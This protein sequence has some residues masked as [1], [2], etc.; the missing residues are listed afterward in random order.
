[1]SQ[2][3]RAGGLH[4]CRRARPLSGCALTGCIFA[5]FFWAAQL[6]AAHHVS[7][8]VVS[9]DAPAAGPLAGIWRQGMC[10]GPAAHACR[11]PRLNGHASRVTPCPAKRFDLQ[12]TS[13][14]AHRARVHTTWPRPDALVALNHHACRTLTPR[15][16]P[17]RAPARRGRP[18]LSAHAA[19]YPSH[20]EWAQRVRDESLPATPRRAVSGPPRKRGRPPKA[21]ALAR[22]EA[23]ARAPSEPVWSVTPPTFRAS[24][25]PAPVSVDADAALDVLPS[26]HAPPPDHTF[27]LAPQEVPPAMVFQ[28]RYCLTIIGD[29]FSWLTA[30]RALSM[31]VLK[32]ATDRVT[33]QHSQL[34]SEEIDGEP[35]MYVPLT[36]AQCQ[37][38]LGRMYQH[39]PIPLEELR[40]AFSFHHNALVVYQLG[41]TA[42]HAASR[43][44]A[45]ADR[46]DRDEMEKVRA[47][48]R[49]RQIRT[50]LM[51]MGERLMRV[52]QYLHLSPSPAHDTPHTRS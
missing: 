19:P 17:S 34:T 39:T 37:R 47:T 5:I 8:T 51:V 40:G 18:P 33:V 43:P 14:V 49:L 36:C 26:A 25:P 9:R 44:A 28:C 24:T 29:S 3:L 1:M 50:L 38:P 4:C 22:A 32:E 12:C 2:A 46:A 6:H 13:L 30:Q 23:A 20:A 31:I 11:A 41:S 48:R 52:E 10:V 7:P 35:S 45:R 42:Q 15:M 27:S 16:Q 21:V